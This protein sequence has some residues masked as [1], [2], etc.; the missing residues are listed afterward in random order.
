MLISFKTN[1]LNPTNAHILWNP[2]LNPTNAHI[3]LNPSPI[4]PMLISFK[5]H[6]STK[7]QPPVSWLSPLCSLPLSPSLFPSSSPLPQLLSH[8]FNIKD[9]SWSLK[10][11]VS[12][13]NELKGNF[14]EKKT[15]FP[16]MEALAWGI[17]VFRLNFL[18]K[19]C[20][21]IFFSHKSPLNISWKIL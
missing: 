3:L 13:D 17:Q 19:G 9:F 14:V 20:S 7:A 8:N 12:C 2:L 18:K 4:Q 10:I 1:F 5:T 15:R 16:C 21:R 11:V 6:F